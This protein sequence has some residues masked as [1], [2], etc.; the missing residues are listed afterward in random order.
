MAQQTRSNTSDV[1][2]AV[3]TAGPAGNGAKGKQAGTVPLSFLAP[4]FSAIGATVI[5][6]GQ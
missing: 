4:S 6:G 1:P 5:R 2:T 3:F